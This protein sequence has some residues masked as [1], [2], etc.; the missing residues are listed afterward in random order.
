MP[1]PVVCGTSHNSSQLENYGHVKYKY[2]SINNPLKK[3][4]K[5]INK[6]QG[7]LILITLE[8]I[9]YLQVTEVTKG[10]LRRILEGRWSKEGGNSKEDKF[11]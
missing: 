3:L 8:H 6:R 4:H 1:F 11:F 7:S 10:Y 5:S 2:K 9:E